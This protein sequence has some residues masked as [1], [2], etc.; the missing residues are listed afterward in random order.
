MTIYK[1]PNVEGIYAIKH[2]NK[3]YNILDNG[4]Y[5]SNS[6]LTGG[7]LIKYKETS[8][9]QFPYNIMMDGYDTYDIS[10]NKNIIY[11]AT[12]W[13]ESE[14]L[15]IV[16]TINAKKIDST[17]Q[18]NMNRI[19]IKDIKTI[20]KE[21]NKIKNLYKEND[22]ILKQQWFMDYVKLEPSSSQETNRDWNKEDII[23]IINTREKQIVDSINLIHKLSKSFEIN[24]NHQMKLFFQIFFN[25]ISDCTEKNEIKIGGL[26]L[27]ER[28]Q[29]LKKQLK[30]YETT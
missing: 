3:I 12:I 9:T 13:N 11:D 8:P 26:P 1:Y 29:Q 2:Q 16:Q 19:L 17:P 24:N 6:F 10:K 21:V 4:Q 15:N 23:N 30:N 28:E 22:I 20:L 14:A 7:I 27:N 5:D 25:K 18:D